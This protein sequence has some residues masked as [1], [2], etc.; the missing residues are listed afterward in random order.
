MTLYKKGNIQMKNLIVTGIVVGGLAAVGIVSYISAYNTGNRLERTIEATFEDNQN[1]LAQYSNRIAEAAQIPAMQR[2]DLTQVVTAALDARYGEE[3]SQAMFQWI[4]EQN[5]SIDSTVYVELQR[6]INA[7][8][9]DF[10]M[11][12]TRLI[13]QKRVYETALGTFWGGTW[14]SVAGYPTVDLDDFVIV[15]NARTND[16]FSTGQ[17]EAIQLRSE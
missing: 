8:R 2:D 15:T 11:A 13:D 4:Q 9:E 12:Q 3:G 6:I 17:E 1:V 14:M 16:A 5:P 10:R 7:G